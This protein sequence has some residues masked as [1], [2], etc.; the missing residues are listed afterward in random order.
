[1]AGVP[2]RMPLVT[3]GF[4]GSL[5][6]AFLLTVMWAWPSTASAS[7]PV[8]PLGRRSTSMTWLSV[9]P[10]TMRRPRLTSVSASTLA[11]LTTCWA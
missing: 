7:L 11:F 2:R 5:G 9:L 4:S 10:D 6:M 8:M 1:M 3:K